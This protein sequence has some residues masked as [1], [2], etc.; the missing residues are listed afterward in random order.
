MMSA[1]G[2]DRSE[3]MG[4][5]VVPRSF[6]VA[7]PD[8]EVPAILA[9]TDS[10]LDL[11][12]LQL[13]R[14]PSKPL[15]F[16]DFQQA[17]TPAVGEPLYALSR[18]GRGFDYAPL[19]QTAHMGGT[20]KKPREAWIVDGALN[21]FGLPVFDA[22]GAPVGAVTTI[23]TRATEGG[24]GSSGTPSV[25]QMISGATG[26]GVDSPLGVFVLPGARVASLVR[27]ARDRAQQL[28]AERAAA[29]KQ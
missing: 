14:P 3:Q 23:V 20:L 11:A 16:V 1:G 27:L 9:A 7:L 22:H 15:P 26:A 25:G 10:A 29:A 28:L 21:A 8:G 5:Q 18:L 13:E 12:F 4:I 19:V 6:S 24:N 2:A 17:A